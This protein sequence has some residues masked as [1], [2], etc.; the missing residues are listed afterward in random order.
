LLQA[1]GGTTVDGV[2]LVVLS[3]C[4]AILVASSGEFHVLRHF[5]LYLY[6]VGFLALSLVYSSSR[7]DGL[8]L[9]LKVVYP[10][11]I[12]LVTVKVIKTPREI[13][14]ALRYWVAGGLLATLIGA[15]LFL[16]QG[17]AG[18]VLGGDFRYSSGLLHPSPF[19]MYMFA[20][21]GLCYALWRAE[22]GGHYGILAV[23][24]GVQA[25]MAETRITWAAM[26][27]GVL[28]IEASKGKGARNI[29]RAV[30]GI[31]CAGVAFSY[32]LQH[33]IGLQHRFFGGEFDPSGS[34]LEIVQNVNSSGRNVVWALT[35]GD[36]WSHNRWIGQGAGSTGPLLSRVFEAAGVP[37]NEYLRVLHDTGIVGL[38]LF[39]IGTIGLFRFL[40]GLLLKSSIMQ[41]K[42]F[43]TVALALL[44]GYV[45]LGISDN[46]LDY[47]L[48]LSQYVFFAMGIAMAVIQGD[49]ALSVRR[50]VI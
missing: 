14:A 12:F 7:L 20:L 39:L 31:V 4:F 22:R 30:G 29:V 37:H 5:R 38:V 25:L 40:R 28:V 11:L 23:V 8:R 35:F 27:V 44:A 42:L 16:I 50:G 46:P 33:S 17:S 43:V 45:V 41:Q 21:F 26:A 34:F 6:F 24:F 2:C 32:A 48:I 18:F 49:G 1:L 36:Y 9:V 13:E 15:A 10:V 47:Y 3:V 19:S